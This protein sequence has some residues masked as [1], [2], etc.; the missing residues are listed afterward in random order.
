ME[1]ENV[2]AQNLKSAMEKRGLTG[3]TLAYASRVAPARISDIVRGKTPNPTI[4]TVM[5][6]ARALDL[7]VDELVSPRQD[8]ANG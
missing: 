5:K 1:C 4:G 7:S 3:H 2:L 6:L 8:V